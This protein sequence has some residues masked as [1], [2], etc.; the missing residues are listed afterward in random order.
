MQTQTPPDAAG[1]HVPPMSSAPA[2]FSIERDLPAGFAAFY[3]PLHAE[4]TPRQQ[5]AIAAR[6]RVL[7]ASQA[8]RKP[9]YPAAGPAQGDWTIELPAWTADQRN[10]M[11]GPA[12]DGELGVKMLNSG[13]PGVMID[14][15]DSMANAFEHTL[16][17]LDNVVAMYYGELTYVDVKRG[18]ATVSIKPSATV[19]WTRVRGLHL[20]QAG[21]YAEP[22]SAS[23]F[24]LALLVYKL[25]FARLRHPL[26]IYI[27]KSESADE[28]LWWRDVF[29]A[30]AKA[31]G[32][33]DPYAIKAMA[34]V[35]AFPMAYECENFAY[36]LR[37]HL[38]ALD[39]GRW[40]YM[41]SLIDF[42][43]DDPAWV[44]PDRNT[45]P[46]DVAFFQ[47]LRERIPEVCHRHGMLAIGGMTALF[48]DR[49]NAELNARA[50]SVLEVDKR[51][52]SN[53]LF[54][55][56]WT[57]HP[58]QNAIAV[59]QF[60]AP[61]Q[62][63][64]RKPGANATPELLP[65]IAGVGERTEAGTRAAVRTA[66]RYRHGYLNGLGASLLDGYMEDLATDRIYR[67]MITQRIRHGMHT[68]A[69]VTRFFDEELARLLD[70][71]PAKDDPA[72][73]ALFRE[74]RAQSEAMIS[75][76]YH[77]PI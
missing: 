64:K 73:A 55:G 11:T 53:A 30:L 69:D 35:E 48:P 29:Q 62:G 46:H 4:F 76:G 33:D 63:F 65:S 23:L 39:L 10:Q 61:N 7:E 45:I 57:G 26:A 47:N 17:G 60:P 12:D 68:A 27:P 14:L 49:T 32:L 20:S 43:L 51:N 13:A 38:L 72:Q 18:G 28:A 25:D 58:D 24:D 66:I 5:A 36:N 15:E 41:A 74:A 2:G 52:E 31:K 56:A 44:L 21:I 71:A 16:A 40:D 37:D 9:Q 8:G 42:N 67:L 22:T 70:E 75:R 6:R 54:D 3:G 59:V 1:T 50:L 77:D 34:L 19:L